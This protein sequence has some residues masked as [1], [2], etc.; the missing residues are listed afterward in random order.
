MDDDYDDDDNDDNDDN[1][2]DDHLSEHARLAK[3][4]KAGRCGAQNPQGG[5]LDLSI[6]HNIPLSSQKLHLRWM[7]HRGAVSG[8]DGMGMDGWGEV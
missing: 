2:G 8:M 4:L 3:L 1:D 6:F 5:R 7:Q